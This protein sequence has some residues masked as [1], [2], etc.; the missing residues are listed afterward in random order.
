MSTQASRA[1]GPSALGVGGRRFIELTL[2]LARSEF[3]LR[4]FGSV[5]GYVWSL[6]RPLLF[7]GVLYL[8]FTQIIHLGKGIPHYGVYLLTSIVLWNYLAEATGNAV[9]CLVAREALVRKIRFPRMAIPL[10]VSLTATFNLAMNAIAVLIFALLN[11]VSPRWSWLEMIPIVLIFVIL[12]TG[13]A[14]VLSAAYVSFRD[15]APIWEVASQ[16]WFY[17]SPIMYVARSFGHRFGSG[18]AHAAMVNPA[19][20]LLTQ[21]GHAFIGGRAFPAADVVGTTGTTIGALALVAVVFAGGWRYFLHEAPRV[22]EN[23]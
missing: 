5:L 1:Y 19:A 12:A 6:A 9:N 16:A 8:F 21:M 14:M 2:T 17:T 22:A 10:S 15:I 20:T 11:G 4:Y 18:V 13:I 23:L 7:F 3:K